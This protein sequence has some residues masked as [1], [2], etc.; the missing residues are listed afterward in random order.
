VIRGKAESVTFEGG[1]RGWEMRVE[2]NV[3]TFCFNIHGC[4]WNLA[5]HADETLGAWRREG[6]D[7]RATHVPR[8]TEEDLEAY[9]LGSPKRV[10]LER[11][12]T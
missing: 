6:E 4:A 8:I 2:T 1:E 5:Q 12:M 3:G 7:A 10:A 9:E 11:E